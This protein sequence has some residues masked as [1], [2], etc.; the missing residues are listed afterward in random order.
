MKRFLIF[1][2]LLVV[3]VP[4]AFAGSTTPSGY[5]ASSPQPPSPPPPPT[6]PGRNADTRAQAEFYRCSSGRCLQPRVDDPRGG[7]IDPAETPYANRRFAI[8][9]MIQ[10]QCGRQPS[11]A[12]AN[13]CAMNVCAANA[14]P[15]LTPP[16]LGQYCS[17]LASSAFGR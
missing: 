9:Q 6:I 12:R 1:L 13:A 14:P 2:V 10:A 8:V 16:Q 7:G 3:G 15:G 5:K 17:T 11:I 4:V